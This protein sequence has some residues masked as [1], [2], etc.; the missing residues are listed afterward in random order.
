MAVSVICGE[1]DEQADDLSLAHRVAIGRMATR[2]K[3]PFPSI[4]EARAHRFTR[5]ELAIIERFMKGAI[6]G[7]PERVRA[8][9][10]Q[11]ARQTGADELMISTLTPQHRERVASYERVAR[12]W[13]LT[14]AERL[15]QE[16]SAESSASPT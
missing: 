10:E 5:E 14:P 16:A 4:E 1:S 6:V 11:I 9:L 3:G 13:G 2:E 15:E 7:G 8:G 12:L